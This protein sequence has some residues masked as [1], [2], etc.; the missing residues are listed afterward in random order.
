MAVD[1]ARRSRLVARSAPPSALREALEAA[2]GEGGVL[3]LG[4]AKGVGKTAW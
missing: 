4:G 2:G 1:V 3:T